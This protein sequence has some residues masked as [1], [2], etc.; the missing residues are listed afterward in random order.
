M[1][2]KANPQMA[3]FVFINTQPK[4]EKPKE[5]FFDKE[6]DRIN[7]KNTKNHKPRLKEPCERI[8]II[9]N[10]RWSDLEY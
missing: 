2:K 6:I 9:L 4:A 5:P 7:E 1:R 3:H 10:R 8:Q